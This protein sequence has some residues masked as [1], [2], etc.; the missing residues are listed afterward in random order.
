M[1]H[2]FR[3]FWNKLG[4]GLIT[5]ASDD[6][7]SGIATYTQAGAAFGMQTLWTAWVTFP[8]MVAIQEMCARIGMVQKKGLTTII[9]QRYPRW[10][11][12]LLTFV[13][14]PAITLNIGANIAAMGAVCNMLYPGVHAN[15]YSLLLVA[16]L[17]YGMIRFS[18]RRIAAVLKWL[19]LVL[20]VYVLVPFFTRPQLLQV[21]QHTFIPSF[22][23][24]REFA[25][26]LVA[27]LG[28]T[29][30]PYLF[31]WQANMERE[32][33]LERHI[34]VD[35]YILSDMRTDIGTGMF[36]SNF[37]MYFIILA[38]GTALY[39]VGGLQLVTVADAARAIEP[40]AGKEAYLLFAVGVIGTGLLA[41]P[42]LAGSISYMV[43]EV[44]RLPEGL[45][46]KFH[47]AKGFYITLVV[48]VTVG[49][50]INLF[51]IS[52]VKALLVT[53]V[54]YGITAPVLIGIILHICNNK[55]IMG[56]YTNTPRSNFWGFLCL[57]LMT[58]AAATFLYLEFTSR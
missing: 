27:I 22:P 39:N 57:A 40:A 29:I 20:L 6:D 15:V 44:F 58:L 37:I 31:F 45:N 3:N 46:R 28:T 30:S 13:S 19:C 26:I 21:L 16:G 18:Y 14:I 36:Y 38:S 7:P 52:P 10:V 49:F 56:A 8:L 43:A 55:S 47:Q 33:V 34:V 51:G 32:E 2:H 1:L 54:V 53:A 11:L 9:R 4:P 17:L 48:A 50:G 24:G 35:K 25:A 5:G 23:S 12:Y 42:V 41:L